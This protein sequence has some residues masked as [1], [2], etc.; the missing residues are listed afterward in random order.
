MV[1]VTILFQLLLSNGTAIMH[2]K[3]VAFLD[4]R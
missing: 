1:Y 2:W 4:V 3:E